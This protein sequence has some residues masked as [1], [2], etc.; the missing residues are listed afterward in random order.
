MNV[1]RAFAAGVVGALVMTLLMMLLRAT[2]THLELETPLAAV[3]GAHSWLAGW[4][5]YLI[6]GGLLAQIYAF[7]FEF[8]LNQAGVGAGLL[9][10]AIHSVL[11]GFVWSNIAGGPGKFW[12]TLSGEGIALLFF[13][14][15]VYGAIVGGLYRTEHTLVE[16]GAIKG[17]RPVKG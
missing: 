11:A 6:I 7:G 12:D 8:I 4:I 5:A 9:F 15:F 14:H 13:L 17:S 16:A 1:G 2:G 10:G 3:F